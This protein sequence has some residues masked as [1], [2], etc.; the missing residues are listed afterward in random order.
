VKRTLYDLV[1]VPPQA[2]RE[3]VASAC[4]RRIAQL[5]RDGSEEARAEIFAV[6]EAWSILGDEKLRAGYDATLATPDPKAVAATVAIT[7]EL[8]KLNVARELFKPRRLLAENWERYRKLVFALVFVGLFALSAAWNQSARVAQQKRIED[9]NYEAEYGEP[10]KPPPGTAA[11]KPQPAE[12]FSAE[13][14]EQE[15]KAREKEIQ[16]QVAREQTA[17]EDEFREKMQRDNDPYAGR[18]RARSR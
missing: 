9:L 3:M 1:G 4:R 11:A 10:R 17:K 8:D 7:A 14:F 18:R 6:R 13:K 12:P 2:P 16:D 15:L 5:E